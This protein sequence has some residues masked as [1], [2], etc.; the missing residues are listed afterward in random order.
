MTSQ[1]LVRWRDLEPAPWKNGGGLT[2]LI[3]RAPARGAEARGAADVDWSVSLAE[4]EADGPFSAFPGIARTLMLV[5][6]AELLLDVDGV[7]R[8]LHVP[9][10]LAFSGD[11]V[12]GCRIPAG[13]ARALNLMTRRGRV[14]GS[15]RAVDV[16][17]AHVAK[18]ADG[19][20]LVL[21]ALTSGLICED[22]TRTD[23]LEAL[24]AV[25]KDAA[26]IVTV[27]GNG[28]LAELR[29]AGAELPVRGATPNAR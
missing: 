21:V 1:R 19:E 9:D 3:A 5:G 11:A 18:V 15:S 8:R 6:G 14:S 22:G 24:D 28:L 16:A 23:A 10:T 2:R 7:Q 17:G 27:T 29:A 26:G 13:P 4:I 12:T 20:A 25:V